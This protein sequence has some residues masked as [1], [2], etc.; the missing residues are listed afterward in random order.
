V[1]CFFCFGVNDIGFGVGGRGG[2]FWV[3]GMFGLFWLGGGCGVVGGVLG[4][5]W[6]V[7]VWVVW[8]CCDFWGWGLC[9]A[10][11]RGGLRGGG[12]VGGGGVILAESNA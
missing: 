6:G 7:F 8:G 3:V 5:W 11:V 10:T 1:W 2:L 9:G 4:G 12:G